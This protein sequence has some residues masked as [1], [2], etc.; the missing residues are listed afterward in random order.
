VGTSPRCAPP[1]PGRHVPLRWT[2]EQQNAIFAGTDTYWLHHD[3]YYHRDLEA[4]LGP[5]DHGSY[6][7]GQK[8]VPCRLCGR[9][10]IEATRRGEPDAK[11]LAYCSGCVRKAAGGCLVDRGFEE[12]WEPLAIWSL[13]QLAAELG[14]PP[15]QAQIARLASTA[16]PAAADRAM[17]IR[18]HVP[19]AGNRRAFARAQRRA[20]LGWA[21]WLNR[22]GLLGDGVQ[23]LRG[24]ITVAS[25]GHL[26]RSLLERHI[27][28]FLTANGIAHEVEP[29]WPTTPTSTPP[30][31]EPTGCSMTEP[32]SRPGGSRMCRAMQ[33]RWSARPS[34]PLARAF[35]SSE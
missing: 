8:P 18:M 10:A 17:L 7:R 3:S 6:K 15:S 4:L 19:R 31:C 33:A 24:T 2:H 27:D 26:C 32:M 22:A 5:N 1:R 9:D 28:D 20:P 25:D 14:G 35:G 34:S 30:V 12:P 16:D 21:D 29:Y 11:P 13:Q 23:T